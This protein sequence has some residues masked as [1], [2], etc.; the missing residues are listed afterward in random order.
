MILY[1]FPMAQNT[2]N[3]T[4]GDFFSEMYMFV[5]VCAHSF[6]NFL[7]TGLIPVYASLCV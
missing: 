3:K 2:I 7:F 1:Y 6:T 5:Y 4:V